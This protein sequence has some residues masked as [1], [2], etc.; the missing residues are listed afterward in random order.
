MNF[1]FYKNHKNLVNAYTGESFIWFMDR[2]NNREN[3]F[4]KYYSNK[5]INNKHKGLVT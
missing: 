5:Y 2:R 1:N 4:G 3:G